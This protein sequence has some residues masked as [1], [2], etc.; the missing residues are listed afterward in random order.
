MI[1]KLLPKYKDAVISATPQSFA[2]NL[3]YY[4]FQDPYSRN[5][6]GIPRIQ[7][8]DSELSLLQAL[9]SFYDPNQESSLQRSQQTENWYQFLLGNGTPPETEEQ[10]IKFIHFTYK[11]EKMDRFELEMALAGFFVKKPL[12]IW[13]QQDY[14]VI[15]DM[16]PQSSLSEFDSMSKTLE[17]EFFIK[18]YFF[19]GK[20]EPGIHQ[21]P[22]RFIEEK[23]LFH[24]ALQLLPNQSSI[25]FERLFPHILLNEM[26]VDHKNHLVRELFQIFAEFQDIH[27][28]IKVYLEANFNLSLTAKK[29]YLHRNTLQYRLDKFAERTG[30]NLKC[31]NSAITVYLACLYYEKR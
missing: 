9:F 13:I 27:K 23:K 4:W 2:E 12:F 15:I 14:A 17:S 10:P 20:Q 5:W 22:E 30:I 7:L 1:K 28:T 3:S 24:L 11:G 26:A 8:T 19:I 25:T 6:I 31:M 21:L 29:L 16:G 18:P